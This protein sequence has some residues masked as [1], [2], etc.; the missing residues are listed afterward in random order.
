[1]KRLFLPFIILSLF[2]LFSVPAF[3]A[4]ALPSFMSGNAVTVPYEATESKAK[5]FLSQITD[6]SRANNFYVV[7]AGRSVAMGLSSSNTWR[8]SSGQ[9][10]Y[11]HFIQLSIMEPLQIYTFEDQPMS[12]GLTQGTKKPLNVLTFTYDN[13]TGTFDGGVLRQV[14][15]GVCFDYI[16]DSAVLF[17]PTTQYPGY[18][19]LG[20][21]AVS[22]IDLDVPNGVPKYNYWLNAKSTTASNYK[23]TVNYVFD[24]GSTAAATVERSYPQG[25]AYSI[26]S[27][28]IAGYY[29]DKGVVKGTIGAKDIN[30]TVTYH[31]NEAYTSPAKKLTIRYV[32][33]DGSSAWTNHVQNANP[34]SFYKV[35]SPRISGYAADRAIVEGYMPGIDFTETVVYRKI[36]SGQPDPPK[37]YYLTIHYLRRNGQMITRESCTMLLP[38]SS[39][40]IRSPLFSYYKPD[41]LAVSGTMPEKN[42][43]INVYY[44]E[45]DSPNTGEGD[46]DDGTGGNSG[47][48]GGNSSSSGGSGNSSGSGSGNSSGSNSGSSSS[49]GNDGGNGSNSGNSSSGGNSSGG[50]SSGS[51]SGD[52]GSSGGNSGSGGSGNSSSG[53]SSGSGNDSNLNGNCNCG[54]NSSCGGNGCTCGKGCQFCPGGDYWR[55]GAGD[56]D[57]PF[58][59]ESEPDTDY[60]PLHLFDPNDYD[61]TPPSSS[62]YDP[63][64]GVKIP[65]Q[66]TRYPVSTPDI[67][68]DNPFPV[69]EVKGG[70]PFPVPDVKEGNPFPVPEVKD[71]NPFP[72]PDIKDGNPFPIPDIPKR[73]VFPVP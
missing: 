1:M 28:S 21:S 3:A 37:Y 10:Q 38:G 2:V 43:E 22:N 44:D 64:D 4:P 54:N 15:Q 9:Y 23:V 40:Y 52:S 6:P 58:P 67:S 59:D 5:T 57:N 56:L 29:T 13:L 18:S 20:Q 16:I 24:N 65:S 19:Q 69:P 49:G 50:S 27:P 46:K 63:L 66:M 34:G 25:Y 35:I 31:K 73:N 33:E 62:D 30:V 51:N 11:L 41:K 71:G 36:G 7:A 53:N 55:P 70:N 42:L 45:T 12:Y 39:Y 48:Q 17:N 8:E 14:P 72:V 61:Y 26:E 68:K 32:F 60:P 47:G